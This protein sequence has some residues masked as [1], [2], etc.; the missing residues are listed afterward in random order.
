MFAFAIWDSRERR[1][2]IARDRLGVKPLVYRLEPDR[3]TFASELKALLQV[4]DAPR[5]LDP[6]ALDHYLTLQYVP[7]PRTIFRGIRKLPPAHYGVWQ[8]GEF[9][10]TR[11][12][13]PDFN[14]EVI[15]S[16]E[17]YRTLLRETLLEATRL[18]MISD[19][20]LGAFLSGGID[21]TI[22][23]G[24]MQQLADRPVKTF[25]IGFPV[26]DFDESRYARMAATHLGTE[27]HEF[28]VQPNCV[29]ILPKLVWHYDEPFAD[30][31]AIP[32]Y[33]VHGG[34]DG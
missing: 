11:Y 25:S 24:L 13:E 33:Y 20:P 28:V 9:Q 15:R 17:E 1:L 12:W 29:E 16:P 5:E 32:T 18:R 6:T 34:I 21:S 30:S 22:T 23:V 8:D 3:L 10:L 4:P 27:H 19:V 26:P 14:Q 31:S 7:H 2:M